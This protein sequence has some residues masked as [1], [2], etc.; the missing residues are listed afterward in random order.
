MKPI[1]VGLKTDGSLP[2]LPAAQALERGP[3]GAAQSE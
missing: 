1:Y 2:T 3:A